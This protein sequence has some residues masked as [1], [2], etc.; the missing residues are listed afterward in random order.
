MRKRFGVLLY[1]FFFT[2]IAG[3]SRAWAVWEY[4]VYGG[5][6]AAVEAW[7]NVSLIFSDAAFET[8]L[9]SAVVLGAIIV[10]YTTVLRAATGSRVDILRNW[11]VPVG[12]GMIVGSV[13]IFPKDSLVIYDEVLQRGPYQVD[14]VPKILAMTAGLTNK[15]ER[16]FIDIVDTTAIDPSERYIYNAGGV[17]YDVLKKI[18]SV[19]DMEALSATKNYVFQTYQQYIKDCVLF[20]IQRSGGTTINTQKL[21]SGQLDP[22]TMISLAKNPAVFTK[23]W[24]SDGHMEDGV[25]C[26]DAGDYLTNVLHTELNLSNGTLAYEVVKAACMT[27]GYAADIGS[28]GRCRSLVE[29]ILDKMSVQLGIASPGIDYAL[30]SYLLSRLLQRVVLE[31][32]PNSAL[33]LI[34]TSQT[35]SSFWGLGEHANSWIIVL[36][37]TLRAFAIAISPFVLL[38]AVTPIAG[39]A[40]SVV[41]GLFIWVTC[42][43]V[44]D[45]VIFTLGKTLAANYTSGLGE[46]MHYGWGTALAFSI[47]SYT[48]KIIATFGALRWS[49]LG[50]ATI[51]TSLLVRFGGAMLAI[52][53]EHIASLPMSAGR[54][55][56]AGLMRNPD[57]LIT[58]EIVPKVSLSNA[59]MAMGG[60]RNYVSGA[61]NLQA[62]RMAGEARVGTS[63]LTH[64]IA[65]ATAYGIGGN[66]AKWTMFDNT[67]KR[68]VFGESDSLRAKYLVAGITGGDVGERTKMR[69]GLQALERMGG[70]FL[71]SEDMRV[72]RSGT[73]ERKAAIW[74]E[75][76]AMKKIDVQPFKGGDYLV[77][78]RKGG[79]VSQYIYHTESGEFSLYDVAFPQNFRLTARDA[80]TIR[81]RIETSRGQNIVR[82]VQK[83]ENTQ[84]T[85]KIGQDAQ[86]ILAKNIE[87]S[88]NTRLSQEM[89]RDKK[90]ERAV[91]RMKRNIDKIVA[92]IGGGIPLTKIE[93]KYAHDFQLISQKDNISA[94]EFLQKLQNVVTE[95]TLDAVRATYTELRSKGWTDQQI[96]GYFERMGATN[97]AAWLRAYTYEHS[98]GAGVERELNVAYLKD[99]AARHG[100]SY[101]EA[102]ID[103]SRKLSE[104]PDGI[105]RDV[106]RFLYDYFYGGYRARVGQDAKVI[107][108]EVDRLHRE[109][110]RKQEEVGEKIEKY[111]VPNPASRME[112]H[113]ERQARGV[114]HN[115]E[116]MGAFVDKKYSQNTAF[117]GFSYVPVFGG[118]INVIGDVV[119]K[120]SEATQPPPDRYLTKPQRGRIILPSPGSG[121]ISSGGH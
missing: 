16:V 97:T 59:A 69:V 25:T 67:Y 99:Y 8:L 68:G 52:V 121:R 54:T 63:F 82:E 44:V 107:G 21:L 55:Y 61:A 24:H 103:I 74:R 12:I 33:A 3:V 104:N 14:N 84:Q 46:G 71:S 37:E 98:E 23:I 41:L 87:K 117:Y 83:I 70:A 65:G 48:T 110:E 114:A 119:I 17:G 86:G 58:G 36:K 26:E 72:L 13:F 10:L 5:Y 85:T 38:F 91:R 76:V 49:G 47:P 20:E 9:T 115:W 94:E 62:G 81:E 11:M 53:G 45:A 43:G 73:P 30:H 77:T 90:F 112:S 66:I 105:Y 1:L 57:T 4:R 100:M 6:N 22:D 64:E 92:S 108:D 120:A 56:G 106:Q 42:W 116:E 111:N 93:A 51:V 89:A 50:L 78:L 95:G 39:R 28:L 27:A 29:D 18:H 35:M 79:G 40:L 113:V 2:L 80:G 109:V 88:I 102:H 96:L 7:K 34:A 60:F 31:D 15:I 19:W 118:A 32:S 75:Q 101:E